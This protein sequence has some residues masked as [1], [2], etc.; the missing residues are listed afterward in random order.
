MNPSN[1]LI[2]FWSKKQLY[3]YLLSLG[4]FLPKKG[5]KSI[6]KSVLLDLAK[7]KTECPT[8]EAVK[9]CLI[10]TDSTKNNLAYAIES[11]LE[12]ENGRPWF[13]RKYLPPKTYLATYLYSCIPN[14]TLFATITKKINL[15]KD[16]K[17]ELGYFDN[18]ENIAQIRNLFKNPKPEAFDHSRDV[19]NLFEITGYRIFDFE[20]IDAQTFSLYDLGE[21][22]V[23]KKIKRSLNKI[24]SLNN[25][26]WNH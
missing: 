12:S 4:Y 20:Q 8:I 18:P 26:N 17:P 3:E 7:Q 22:K 24:I 5:H 19:R 13:S 6:H 15:K 9:P 16:E 10:K 25:L 1:Y 21:P 23:S 11:I 14:H 2:E